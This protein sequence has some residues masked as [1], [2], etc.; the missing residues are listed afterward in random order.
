M[1]S[2]ITCECCP[3]CQSDEDPGLFLRIVQTA[4]FNAQVHTANGVS[5]TPKLYR[6]LA[7]R[8]YI[9]AVFGWL[10]RGNRRPPKACF[11][12]LV[13]AEWTELSPLSYVGYYEVAAAEDLIGNDIGVN[14]DNGVK[15]LDEDPI[16]NDIGVNHNNGVKPLVIGDDYGGGDSVIKPIGSSPKP[17]QVNNGNVAKGTLV[18]PKLKPIVKVL[19]TSTW[20]KPINIANAKSTSANRIN[21]SS[22]KSN[23]ANQCGGGGDSANRIRIAS[24]KSTSPKHHTQPKHG[25][26]DSANRIY[27]ASAKST[28]A[29]Q[30]GGIGDIANRIYIASAKSTSTKQ[31]GGVGNSTNMIN[32]AS[33]KSTLANQC[34]GVGDSANMMKIVNAKYSANRIYIPSAKST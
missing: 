33:A 29:K 24:A 4:E 27:I 17:N 3:V 19:G 30:C 32:I 22:A 21:I 13:R 8:A 12:D 20:L 16:G 34:G 25:G 9:V 15:P 11:V 7:Y 28:S 14:H 6:K 31:C 18:G 10:G 23:L 2:T 1:N 26:G 5:I